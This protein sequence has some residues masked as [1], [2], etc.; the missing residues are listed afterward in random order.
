MIGDTILI[1]D[2]LYNQRLKAHQD[3]YTILELISIFTLMMI[4]EFYF[5]LTNSLLLFDISMIIGMVWFIYRALAG[6]N[7]R[8]G[9]YLRNS[10]VAFS[11]IFMTFIMEF[12]MGAVL[13]F[14]EGIFFAWIIRICI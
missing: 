12:F 5:F 7:P 13:D 14:I 9:N 8:K 6:P 2:T 11:I 3:T 4:G 10:F 1:Y